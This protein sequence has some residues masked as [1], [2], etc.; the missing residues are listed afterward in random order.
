MKIIVDGNK[1]YKADFILENKEFLI[2]FLV[3]VINRISI[4]NAQKPYDS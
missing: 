3:I 2:L 4:G 1:K